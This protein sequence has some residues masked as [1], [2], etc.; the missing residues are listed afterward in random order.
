MQSILEIPAGTSDMNVSRSEFDKLKHRV[1]ILEVPS[2]EVLS[3]DSLSGRFQ[4]TPAK[5]FGVYGGVI[6]TII[7][8]VISATHFID[9]EIS[10]KFDGLTV[11]M[12]KIEGAVKVLASKQSEQTQ[13]LIR[14]LLASAR[15]SVDPDTSAVEIGIAQALLAKLK[16]EKTQSSPQFFEAV[17]AYLQGFRNSPHPK[18]ATT[19]F[20]AQRLLADYRSSLE[21][22]P[23]LPTNTQPADTLTMPPSSRGEVKAS[24]GIYMITKGLEI[25]PNVSFVGYGAAIDGS[26]IPRTSDMLTPRSMQLSKNR[27]EVEGLT[28]IG[29]SQDL[30]GIFWNHVTFL[31]ERIK[32]SGGSLRLEH[33]RFVNCTFEIAHH[34]ESSKILEYAALR[35]DSLNV[36][37]PST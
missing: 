5:A 24:T 34:P 22:V 14:T 25:P 26:A 33:V 20:T 9:N 16:Q 15:I 29:A 37:R 2:R 12:T 7:L 11:R 35:R 27:N 28:L 6:L 10:A 23:P 18:M 31:N 1:N 19:A 17:S 30:G 21:P 13:E 8:A 32:Y 3:Q 4:W 36:N